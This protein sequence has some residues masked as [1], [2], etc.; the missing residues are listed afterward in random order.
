MLVKP[1]WGSK[2]LNFQSTETKFALPD[3]TEPKLI[4]DM[5]GIIKNRPDP[6]P[7]PFNPEQTFLDSGLKWGEEIID[8]IMADRGRV[9]IPLRNLRGFSELDE[10]LS[11]T[12]DAII[13]IDWTQGVES[14]S[15]D[16]SIDI[17]GLLRLLHQ[18][19]QTEILIYCLNGDYPY[20]PAGAASNLNIKIATLSE[21]R[22]IPSWAQGA[23]S[24]E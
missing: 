4:W 9:V 15:E 13:G 7:L 19:N 21:A 3:N 16:F 2:G 6:F 17:V 1:I 5:R 12:E 14:V 10:A 23:F 11:Y 24:F 8:L 22:H 20:I 18:R